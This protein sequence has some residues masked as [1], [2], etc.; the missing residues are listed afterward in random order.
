MQDFWITPDDNSII[1]V[2]KNALVSLSSLKVPSNVKPTNAV[3][4]ILKSERDLKIEATEI[5]YKKKKYLRQDIK[6][7]SEIEKKLIK[8]DRKKEFES[9]D[10][11]K[12]KNKQSPRRV[13]V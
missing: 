7:D 5:A 3:K 13:R 9:R 8:R 11:K 2:N 1:D 12:I 6:P 4:T 10:S